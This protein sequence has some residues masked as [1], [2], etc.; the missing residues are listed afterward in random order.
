M[1]SNVSE[2]YLVKVSFQ[3]NAMISDLRTLR[4][5]FGGSKIYFLIDFSLLGKV[6]SFAESLV[7][8]IAKFDVYITK[9]KI[10]LIIHVSSQQN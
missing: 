3:D 9:I 6:L 7:K 2:S 1:K 4:Y 8:R 10:D 5:M